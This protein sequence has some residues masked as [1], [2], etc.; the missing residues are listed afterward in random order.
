MTMGDVISAVG[1]KTGVPE[2]EMK[3]INWSTTMND[4][5][6]GK[7][8]DPPPKRLVRILQKPVVPQSLLQL[9]RTGTYDLPPIDA[10]EFAASEQT[11]LLEEFL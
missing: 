11:S 9:R 7:M 2:R 5:A 3:K 8:P 10:D 1:I 6:D 4:A